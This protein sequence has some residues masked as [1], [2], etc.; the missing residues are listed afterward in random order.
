L[1]PGA[2]QASAEA[3][4]TPPLLLTRDDVASLLNVPLKRVTWWLYALQQDRRYTRIELARRSGSVPREINAPIK[5]IKDMQR[6][7]ATVLAQCYEPPVNVHGFVPGRS[8][9]SNARQHQKQRWVLKVDLENF[10]PSINFGRVRGMF[11]AFPFEYPT[12]VATL[13]AQLCCHR[14]QLPQ[15]APTSPIVSNF[16]CRRLDVQLARMARDERCYYTRYADDICFSTNRSTFPME[17]ATS[18][19]GNV[20]LGPPLLDT[21]HGNGFRINPA[22]TRLVRYTRR[23][24]VTGLVVNDKVNVDRAYVRSLRNVLYIWRRYGEEKAHEAFLKANFQPNRPPEKPAAPF[25]RI[26]QGRVQHVGSVKGWT[27]RVYRSLAETL[28]QL[29]ETFR[30]RTLLTLDSVQEVRLFTEGESDYLHLMAAQEYF[31]D[32]NEFTDINLVISAETNAG[33]DIELLRKCQGLAMTAQPVPSVC[34]FAEITTE[35]SAM[36]S[37]VEMT[38]TTE[39]R[40]SRS[41]SSRPNGVRPKFVSRCSTATKTL[42]GVMLQEGVFT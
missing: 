20:S 13:L 3:P 30:P 34:V 7:L 39:T 35:Y 9:K 28:H 4:A 17:L 14:N 27:N 32:R 16:I 1:N 37:A 11:M 19:G 21:I 22:K 29:D 36:P 25:N 6:T 26:I 31:H 2:A 38:D 42:V 12:D 18:E 15:G 40:S 24:R 8:P 5:P 33:N 10:F 41:P 23:Q